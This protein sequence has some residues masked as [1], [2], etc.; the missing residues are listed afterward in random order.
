MK[1]WFTL[2]L[3]VSMVPLAQAGFEEGVNYQK[4]ASPQPTETDDK[5]E[6]RELFWYSCPHC[7][8]LEPEVESWLERKPDDVDFVRMP[9]VLG[10]TW[11]LLARAYYTAEL[12]DA[13]DKI[14]K[15]LFERLHKERKRI[16]N[17][18]ELKEFFVEHGVSAE[19]FDNTF[20]SFAVVTKTNRAK[21]VRD[22]YGITGVPA[23]VVNGKYLVTAK[24]AG[25][26]RQMFEVVDYLVEQERG[27]SPA[28]AAAAAP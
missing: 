19:D 27:T 20:S 24:L 16:R 9:A 18:E 12:L 15:P 3:L 7:Y 1:H 13:T 2:L 14:H 26:N 25:G 22:M 17:A 11:E 28:E 21:Q 8:Q 10:P 4:I 5:I 23:L 6:V